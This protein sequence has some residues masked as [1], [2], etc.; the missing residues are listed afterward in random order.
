MFEDIFIWQSGYNVDIPICPYTSTHHAAESPVAKTNMV[1]YFNIAHRTKIDTGRTRKTLERL[2]H[3]CLMTAL[4]ILT[5][6][7]GTNLPLSVISGTYI[8]YSLDTCH[9]HFSFE[10]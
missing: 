2:M 6:E 1:N 9:S 5:N 4:F 8:T 3:F 7:R 10:W